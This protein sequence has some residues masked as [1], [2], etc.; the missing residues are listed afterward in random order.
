MQGSTPLT[1]DSK[2]HNPEK[3]KNQT[4]LRSARSFEQAVKMIGNEPPCRN[5][6]TCSA[7]AG[8]R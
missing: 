6:S 2:T 4:A 8:A 3:I 1:E 7:W 5:K